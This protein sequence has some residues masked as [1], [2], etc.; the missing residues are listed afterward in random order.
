[1]EEEDLWTAERLDCV[2][3]PGCN[4]MDILEPTIGGIVRGKLKSAPANIQTKLKLPMDK[5]TKA[6]LPSLDKIFVGVGWDMGNKDKASGKGGAEP[7]EIDLDVSAVLF[8]EGARSMGA[9]YYNN[10]RQFGISHTGDN[11]TGAGEGDDEVIKVEMLRIPEIVQQIHFII[12]IYTKDVSFE[13]LQNAYC[14]VFDA[15]GYELARYELGNWRDGE[16]SASGLV[17]A[18]L[19][20]SEKTKKWYF[21]A[22][23]A[24]CPGRRWM[25]RR[26]IEEMEMLFRKSP[27]EIQQLRFGG[28]TGAAKKQDSVKV[29]KMTSELKVTQVKSTVSD[30][31]D[32]ARFGTTSSLLFKSQK[33]TVEVDSVPQFLVGIGWDVDGN[34]LA[35]MDVSAVFFHEEGRDMGAVDFEN[36][37]EMGVRHSGDN[38]T[39]EGDGDDEVVSVDLLA[40][41]KEVVQIFF[42][43]NVYTKGLYFSNVLNAQCRIVNPGN[44][45][46]LVKYE[47]K[48]MRETE[49]A[50][51]LIIAQL[52]RHPQR[53]WCFKSQRVFCPGRT[54]L[55]PVM[56]S[57]M[58]ALFS[59]TE[60]ELAPPPE[61][62]SPPMSPRM[63]LWRKQSYSTE[64]GQQ[65]QRVERLSSK[66]GKLSSGAGSKSKFNSGES[67]TVFEAGLRTLLP[68]RVVVSL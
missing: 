30:R 37:A 6:D 66:E 7:V 60:E 32:A 18:R 44:N 40:I 42:T 54:W 29:E 59:K 58:K 67:G 52:F 14:R 16:L 4:F 50:T 11:T 45:E 51:G 48:D 61:A 17:L 49:E 10:T 38:R 36:P 19:V 26:C 20:R 15:Q 22:I 46:E 27:K 2:A 1:M 8:A 9:V 24:F 12:N 41:P 31:L 63:G 47:L 25:D 23:G 43:V 39:G 53:G 35:D 13:S 64:L 68:R 55:D 65:R 34:V 5:G 3:E 62:K 28:K 33:S 56:M 57:E 21:Q